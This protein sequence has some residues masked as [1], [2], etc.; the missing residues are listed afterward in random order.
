MRRIKPTNMV[1]MAAH[2]ASIHAVG[3]TTVCEV[4]YARPGTPLGTRV[5]VRSELVWAKRGVQA[6]GQ[7]N[8]VLQPR[9]ELHSAG[10]HRVDVLNLWPESPG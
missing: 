3:P 7:A 8:H 1:A 6:Q 10:R 9:W 2:G 4:G 5:P